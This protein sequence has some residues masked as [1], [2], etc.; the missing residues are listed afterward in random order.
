MAS[1]RTVGPICQIAGKPVKIDDGTLCRC[2]SPLP[3]TVGLGHEPD[4]STHLVW[5]AAGGAKLGEESWFE[6][7]Y[8]NL[9][10]D[11]R[12]HFV[13]IVNTWIVQNWGAQTV[14]DPKRRISIYARQVGK[15]V[16][17]DNRFEKCG[18]MP[19]DAGEAD[20]TLGSFAIDIRSKFDIQYATAPVRG[21]QFDTFT[22]N[23]KMYVDDTL[24]LQEDN[25]IVRYAKIFGWVTGHPYLDNV[26]LILAPSRRVTRAEWTIQGGG[27]RYT[28]KAGDTLSGLA[29]VVYGDANKW[30]LIHNANRSRVSSPDNLS[31]GVRLLI[32]DI[33]SGLLH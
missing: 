23:T 8:P 29:R 20:K 1:N 14:P 25:K 4:I 3:R 24:G 5:G 2:A 18:D 27:I 7:R 11:A 33:K 6:Q 9:I 16:R 22:W 10:E 15:N 26:L 32:P 19:Q 31:I 21:V 17:N 13:N 12:L 28:V 30:H